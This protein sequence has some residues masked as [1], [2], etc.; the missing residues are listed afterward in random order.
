MWGLSIE[1]MGRARIRR[2]SRNQYGRLS[3]WQVIECDTSRRNQDDP[4]GTRGSHHA[5]DPYQLVHL[6]WWLGI[7][8]MVEREYDGSR[9]SGM[10]A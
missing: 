10:G 8:S 6:I 2:I 3:I 7:E 5:S 1:S 4:S 9:T